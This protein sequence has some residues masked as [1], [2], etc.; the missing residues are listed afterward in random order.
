MR[1]LTVRVDDGEYGRFIVTVE[2]VDNGGHE[3]GERRVF[4]RMMDRAV[5]AY[6]VIESVERRLAA[7][8]AAHVAGL[9][10]PLFPDHAAQE[11]L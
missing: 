8:D 2:G 3:I 1:D 9:P 7:A 11:M 4:G 5:S 10:C 6:G